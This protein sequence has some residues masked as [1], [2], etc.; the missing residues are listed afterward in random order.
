MKKCI[1]AYTTLYVAL[2]SLFFEDGVKKDAPDWLKIFK[3]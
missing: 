2:V 3:T 1:E